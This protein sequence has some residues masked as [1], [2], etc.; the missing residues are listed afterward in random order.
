[1]ADHD[2]LEQVRA[3]IAGAG[4]AAGEIFDEAV[5]HNLRVHDPDGLVLELTAPRQPEPWAEGP[6]SVPGGVVGVRSEP[7]ERTR[8]P[9]QHGL[10]Q[11]LGPGGGGMGRHGVRG[12]KPRID[13]ELTFELNRAPVRHAAAGE[14]ARR[15]R[16]CDVGGA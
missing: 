1:M 12:T 15:A 16:A 10:P 2:T 3:T 5:S 13:S 4:L 14:C 6:S 11:Q 7:R 9:S 8:L